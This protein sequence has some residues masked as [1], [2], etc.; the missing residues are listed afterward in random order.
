[1]SFAVRAGSRFGRSQ[2][3][4]RLCEPL[5]TK[6]GSSAASFIKTADSIMF[7]H[8]S[9]HYTLVIPFVKRRARI[10]GKY[11][12]LQR[13]SE[14]VMVMTSVTARL[15]TFF[16]VCTLG[17]VACASNEETHHDP[18]DPNAPLAGVGPILASTAGAAAMNTVM[19][20]AT[21]GASAQSTGQMTP[22]ANGG[23]FSQGGAPAGAM[24]A[25][26]SPSVA[27]APPARPTGTVSSPPMQVPPAPA[28]PAPL[29]GDPNGTGPVVSIPDTAC[30]PAAGL[31]AF[32]QGTGIPGPGSPNVKIGGKDV[33]LSYPCGLKEGAHVTFILN[34][35]GT[36]PE[37]TLKTYQHGY[38]S[39]HKLANSHKLIVATPKS[40]SPVG[41]WGNMDGGVDVP[42]LYEVVK[43]VYDKFSKF[44][45]SGMWIAG[46]SWGSMFAK[47]FVCDAMFKD[48]VRGVIGMS[49]G[50]TGVAG[51]ASYVSQIHTVGD[52]EGGESGVPDQTI[53]A[54]AHGCAARL[55][56]KDIGNGQMLYEWP[57]C[58]R[59]RVHFN[60]VM[61]NHEHITAIDDPVV[62][63][64]VNAIKSTEQ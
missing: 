59:G 39:A 31:D 62:L 25:A 47:Q 13:Q 49:G 63:Y 10:Q 7:N 14:G 33:V 12:R 19:M 27:N 23:T 40:E 64:I 28:A 55:P 18:R 34:L 41:Q 54:T 2:A 22:A 46:H 20:P 4:R 53:D 43:W 11:E 60:F 8:R 32:V 21:A 58:N 57:N 50:P 44:Q 45:I 56:P 37:E 16:Y 24:P 17:L 48:K 38:F 1:V 29:S 52:K 35:H 9:N 6:R 15:R 5:L 42:H 26:G 61:G 36:M 3:A 51:C 30:G